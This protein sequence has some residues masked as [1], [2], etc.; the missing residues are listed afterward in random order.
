MPRSQKQQEGE[1]NEVRFPPDGKHSIRV[2]QTHTQAPPAVRG[3]GCVWGGLGWQPPGQSRD[4]QK[5]L[6]V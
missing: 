4:E 2:Q 1:K 6:G 5:L 3:V